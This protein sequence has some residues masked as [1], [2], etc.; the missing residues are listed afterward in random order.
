MTS[1]HGGTSRRPSGAATSVV[2]LAAPKR[3]RHVWLVVA[4]GVLVAGSLA[5]AVAGVWL[6][7]SDADQSQRSF[8]ASSTA[9]ASKL[10]LALQHEDDLVVSASAFLIRDP[11]APT[12][13]FN[14]WASVSRVLARYPEV[15]GLGFAVIVPASELQAYSAAVITDPETPFAPNGAFQVVPPGDRPF[16]CFARL[17]LFRSGQPLAPAGFDYCADTSGN[18]VL[19]GRDTGLSSYAPLALGADVTWLALETPMYR[20]GAV[21][22]TVAERRDAFIGWAGLVVNPKA[23]LDEALVGYPNTAVTFRF[24]SG[25]ADTTF[26]SGDAAGG[27]YSHRIDLDN[28]WTVEAFGAVKTGAVFQNWSALGVMAGGIGFSLLLGALILVLATGRVRALGLVREKTDELQHQALHDALTGLP[29]RAL[30]IDRIEQLLA[31]SR[32]NAT[33]GATLFIDLDGF[34]NVNDTLGHEA[35]DRLLQLVAERLTATLR[36]ADTIGRMGG[37]EFVVLIDGGSLDVGPELVAERLLEVMRQP[38]ALADA[39]API[40]V[41]ASIGIA[42]ASANTAADTLRDADMAL[43]EAKAAGRNCYEIF[44]PEMEATIRHRYE[45]E[46]DLRAASDDHQFRLVYQPIYNL[47]DLSVVGVEALIRWE[48]PTLGEIQPDDFVPLLESSGQIVEVG[49]WVLVEA[50]TQ[51]A[52]WRERGSDLIV[53]VNVSGRQLDHDTI[54]DDV[55]DALAISGLDAASLT[56][57]VTETALMRNVENAARRLGDLKA[58]GVQV[59]IDDFGT[60]YSSLAYLQRLP[61]DCLKIDRTFTDALSKSPDSDAIVHTLVQLG[62]DL[63]LKTLAEGVETTDQIDQLRGQHVDE[64]QGFLF[65]RPLAPEAIEAE[66]LEPARAS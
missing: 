21:P 24:Q 17:G 48:H 11:D 33:S 12:A 25:S 29:N 39:P 16:Y 31:R 15:E 27:T 36:D 35:G 14:E 9:I 22:A 54:V 8:V 4:A 37:D 41:T 45:L 56:I 42:V 38:F 64:V 7:R 26:Q 30:I 10:Q 6:A 66:L 47:D 23:V 43:Y 55:R 65:A 44:R 62:K 57:E 28:G 19:G 32:R 60:G 2:D 3:R 52:A 50:C 46:F 18:S 13:E 34:K 58:L 59:A 49:R 61:V 40:V 5:S 51:M 63:G 1:R 53:S 20:G